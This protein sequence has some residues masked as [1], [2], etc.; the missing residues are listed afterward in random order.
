MYIFMPADIL[1]PREELLPRW[2]VIA[3]DQFTS[4][5]AYWNR[6]REFTKDVPSAMH[7]ILPEAELGTEDE[8]QKVASIHEAMERYIEEGY[9][10]LF[11]NSYIYVERTL[12]NGMIRP[13]LIGAVDLEHY[14]YRHDSTS[15]IRATEKTVL[16][17][18]PPRQR[19]RRG[20]ALE[21]PHV[22][23]LCDDEKMQLIEP[24]GAVKDSL[25]KLYEL[26][27]VQDGGHIVGYLV[28]GAA[29]DAF[30]ARLASYAETLEDKYPD[31]NGAKVLLA[32]GDGN[33]S[34]ATAKSCYEE[35]KQ[36]HPGED[37]SNHPARYALVELENIH[38]PSQQFEPIH[39][40]V[41]QTD[42]EK[43]LRDLEAIC[44]PGGYPVTWIMGDQRGKLEL[45]RELGELDVAVL[46]NFLDEWLQEN[47]GVT[48]YIHGDT[49]VADLAKQKNT[50]GLLLQPMG[51]SQLFRGVIAGGIL[52]RKTFS[53]G[54]AREKRYYLEGRK[55]K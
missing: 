37:L 15:L 34:L 45:S 47:P 49:E 20:A 10:R 11:P 18:I 44:Q 27:L 23:M 24:I 40:V 7:L 16:E 4:D 3:C 48:D 30:N 14:D 21:L 54:H 43:L 31:L 17:R 33:H 19:V 6:V 42:A 36:A 50:L 13:G 28:D 9:L 55:I 41:M 22:M 2:P 26:D 25:L 52:P 29:A 32:V 12:Q 5:P 1:L 35:M 46:Q 51:K 53:M 39:R 8:E 38:D